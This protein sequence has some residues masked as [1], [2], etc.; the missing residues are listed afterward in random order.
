MP[1]LEGPN[2]PSPEQAFATLKHLADVFLQGRAHRPKDSSLLDEKE[3]P[4]RTGTL[5][6]DEN[7]KVQGFDAEAERLFGR[8]FKDVIGS[9][10]EALLAKIPVRGDP[11]ASRLHRHDGTDLAVWVSATELTF[12]DKAYRF[13][14]IQ[15]HDETTDRRTELRYRHLVE[16]IPAV[17]FTAAL[18]GGLY[19]LYV[20][21]QI[22]NLLGYSQKQWLADPVLW[23]E[24]LHVDDRRK[25]DEEFARGCVTGGPFRADCRFLTRDDRVVWVH[26]EARIIKDS[27]G[28]PLLLQG[29]AFDITET[30]R[31]E[32]LIRASLEEK[33]TLL[34]E[35]HH[36]VKNN[37]Q[38]TSSLLRLQADHIKDESAKKALREGQGRIRSMALVHELLYRSKDLSRVNLGEYVRDLTRQLLRAYAVERKQIGIE[39]KLMPV[40]LSI[41]VAIPCGLILNELISNAVRHAFPGGRQGKIHIELRAGEAFTEL[42]VRDDGIGMPVGVDSRTSPTL[43]LRLIR[44]LAEQVEGEL[45]VRSHGGTEV[46]LRIPRRSEAR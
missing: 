42:I 30:K 10:A 23:Y 38:V 5:L 9:S 37:L 7:G 14:S 28:L 25:L 11:I 18:D 16:Q 22:E 44:T 34:K 45:D 1:P 2:P 3:S 8:P 15:E 32:E 29:V 40:P 4:R 6:V 27:H 35:I 43:G 21:P 41:D 39:T 24:R 36:R 20:S 13:F 31:A 17:V 26:G 12:A 33:E 46:C 19:D